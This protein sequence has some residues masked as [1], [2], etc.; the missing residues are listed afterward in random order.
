[1]ISGCD[2]SFLVFLTPVFYHFVRG[3]TCWYRAAQIWAGTP[4]VPVGT[5]WYR[6]VVGYAAVGAAVTR[7]VAGLPATWWL[8]PRRT[9]LVRRLARRYRA[10]AGSWFKANSL[11]SLTARHWYYPVALCCIAPYHVMTCRAAG[12]APRCTVVA[13]R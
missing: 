5:R 3:T 1:M 7:K 2:G 11:A 6:R 8:E 4:V 12:I 9:A 13:Q 10:G